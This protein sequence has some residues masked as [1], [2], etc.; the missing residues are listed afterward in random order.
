[1]T[2]RTFFGL[3]VISGHGVR[4]TDIADIPFAEFW[5]ESAVGSGQLQDTKTGNWLV[6]LHDWKEFSLLF[7]ATGR[8]RYIV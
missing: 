5:Q 7:I 8:H 3:E 4:L 2:E 1:M 6:H